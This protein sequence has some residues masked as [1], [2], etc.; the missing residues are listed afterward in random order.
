M[1]TLEDLRIALKGGP[2]SG[3]HGH[4]GRPGKRGG[5]SPGKGGGM[6]K[7]ERKARGWEKVAEGDVVSGLEVLH[8]IPNTGS[9]RATF[10]SPEDY[11]TIGLR[12]V[13]MSEFT[14]QPGE[15]ELAERIEDS[16][17]LKP[18]IVIVDGHPDG[19]GYV[20]EGSHRIDALAALEVS[21]FPALV[22]LDHEKLSGDW[23][24]QP[25]MT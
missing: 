20:L 10:S 8:D 5:S 17:K 9:I 2:G 24:W 22:V 13:P 16:G 23:E 1:S 7:A 4:A 3:H 14:L 21:T 15:Y 19:M 12:E 25:W 18:L 6:S 11:E